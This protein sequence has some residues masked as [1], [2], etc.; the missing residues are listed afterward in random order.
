MRLEEALELLMNDFVLDLAWDLREN[1]KMLKTEAAATKA[2]R[3]ISLHTHHSWEE[4]AVPGLQMQ[5]E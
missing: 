2:G 3:S 5:L 4:N 1:D